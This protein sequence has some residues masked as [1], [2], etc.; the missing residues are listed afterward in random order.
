[1]ANLRKQERFNALLR[2]LASS[3]IRTEIGTG[4]IVTVMRVETTGNLQQAKIFISIF[5][6]EKEKEIFELLKKKSFQLHRFFKSQLR[7]KFLPIVFFEIDR[8]AKIERKIE[9]IL[10]HVAK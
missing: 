9:E 2:N 7:M 3:F 8:A 6:E 10:G 1:V 5:P 4:A